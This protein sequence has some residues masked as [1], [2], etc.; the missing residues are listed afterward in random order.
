MTPTCKQIRRKVPKTV[1][2]VCF[3]AAN[4]YTPAKE[5]V[6]GLILYIVAHFL[7]GSELNSRNIKLL[8]LLVSGYC[9]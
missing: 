8:G 1:E 9:V 4:I 3:P 5:V 6:C 7:Y 2:N